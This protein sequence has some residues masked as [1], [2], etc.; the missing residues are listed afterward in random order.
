MQ[1]LDSLLPDPADLT[2]IQAATLARVH[3]TTIRRWITEGL[4]AYRWGK[5]GRI[6]VRP[7]DLAR[8]L[9]EQ[10]HF[11]SAGSQG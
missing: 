6:M 11:A 4:T 1:L 9:Q 3:P 10:R 8:F 2:L 5:G 7:D